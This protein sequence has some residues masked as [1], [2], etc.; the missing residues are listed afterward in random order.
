MTSK[1]VSTITSVKFHSWDIEVVP[2]DTEET[3]YLPVK[4]LCFTVGLNYAAQLLKMRASPVL[5]EGIREISITA[6]DG[7]IYKTACLS[8]EALPFWL[9]TI[10]VNKLP[11]EKSSIKATII[12]FQK[13]CAKVLR[14][15]FFGKTSQ[16]P[17]HP[18]RQDM[19]NPPYSSSKDVET[20]HRHLTEDELPRVFDFFSEKVKTLIA[21]GFNDITPEFAEKMKAV[22]IPLIE[23]GKIDA[24]SNVIKATSRV[25][26]QLAIVDSNFDHLDSILTNMKNKAAKANASTSTRVDEVLTVADKA[27]KAALRAKKLALGTKKIVDPIPFAELIEVA[28]KIGGIEVEHKY[29]RAKLK[30]QA[31][32]IKAQEVKFQ[33]STMQYED[34]ISCLENTLLEFGE[35][36]ALVEAKFKALSAK[37]KLKK[38]SDPNVVDINSKRKPK[39]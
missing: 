26:E 5:N 21:A 32:R 1:T 23:E 16:T 10:D 39:T 3:T 37:P 7:K 36:L 22:L 15:H 9:A 2:G 18:P 31:V 29:M 14:N 13:E 6:S 24:I 19:W 20:Y 30:A 4:K 25:D 38:F 28:K 35:K 8:L 12:L 11:N 17:N 34:K 33:A 27:N